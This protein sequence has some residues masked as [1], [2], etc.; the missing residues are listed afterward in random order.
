MSVNPEETV[1]KAIA[2][3]LE[4][5]KNDIS[6]LIYQLTEILFMNVSSHLNQPCNFEESNFLCA[7]KSMVYNEIELSVF[8][9][10]NNENIIKYTN[11]ISKQNEVSFDKYYLEYICKKRKM[12]LFIYPAEKRLES[13]IIKFKS[14]SK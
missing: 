4:F 3:T 8:S 6:T 10:L 11:Q 5:N 13:L 2:K 7:I 1:Q 14:I 9:I 12:N